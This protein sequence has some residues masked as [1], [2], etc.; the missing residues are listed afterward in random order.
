MEMEEILYRKFGYQ[1]FKDGQ[2]ETIQHILSRHHTIAILPTGTGKSLCYQFPSYLL[3]GQTLIISPLVS[4]MEDQVAHLQQMGEKEAVALNSLLSFEEKN[5]LLNHLKQFKFIFLSP[6]MLE[7]TAVQEKL[8]T[9]EIGLF[10]VDEAHCISQWGVDFRP[11]YSQ[12]KKVRKT[13][14]NPLTL[15][16]TAT[17]TP[18]VLADIKGKLLAEDEQIATVIKSVNRPNI[19]YAVEKNADKLRYIIDFVEKFAG[20]GL[21]YFSSKKKAEAISEQLLLNTDKKVAFYHGDMSSQDRISIQTQFIQG[22]LDLL[23]ATSAFGMGINKKDIRYI[24]HYHLPGSVEAYLQETGRAGRD[25]EKSQTILLYEKGDE[26]IHYRLQETL[27]RQ[28]EEIQLYLSYPKKK[29]KIFQQ[30]LDQTQQ[31]WLENEQ[32][33]S[34]DFVQHLEMKLQEKRKSVAD[35]LSYIEEKKCRR[36]FLLAYFGEQKK[37]EDQQKHSFCCDC[38]TEVPECFPLSDNNENK[39]KELPTTWEEELK[40][41]FF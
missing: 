37:Q 21:I 15:A 7:Q 39:V 10:V 11:E 17:A 3:E 36:D 23:C 30:N 35:M 2:K 20:P 14:Q 5:Y 26:W 38:C 8:Q 41:L 27:A 19:Y 16:L 1:E 6:E 40:K 28:I 12:L 32:E 24:I 34:G 18:E 22:N 33:D 13:L 31:K 29:Q 25:G 9:L 4:L